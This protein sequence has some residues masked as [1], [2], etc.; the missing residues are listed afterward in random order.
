MVGNFIADHLK[1]NMRN[2]FNGQIK[3]G[4]QLHHTIDAFTDAH[5]L[6]ALSK[7]RLRPNMNKY[8]PVVIDVYYDHFLAVNWLN[9]HPT[10]LPEFVKTVYKKL[11]KYESIL[12]PRTLY[13]LGFMQQEN[14]LAGYAH[15]KNLEII[16]GNMSK[17]AAFKNN[18][19]NAVDYLKT[20]YDL[21][22]SEFALFFELLNENAT[23]FR[24]VHGV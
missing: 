21:F 12:P 18:M 23:A 16:F 20:D 1:G 4:I 13:M 6:V 9:Y 8:T 24:A 22:Q 11:I 5:P 7:N 2:A 3:T 10:P 17:R 14:W 19:H 15:F